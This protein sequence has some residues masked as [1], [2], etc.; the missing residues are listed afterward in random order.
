VNLVL[1]ATEAIGERGGTVTLRTGRR[2][3]GVA[4]LA[5]AVVGSEHPPGEYVFVDVPDNGPGV[6]PDV[7]ACMFD[8]FFT[9]KDAGHGLGLAVVVGVARAHH[10]AL[11][12]T[13]TPGEGTRFALYFAPY[14]T[15]DEERGAGDAGQV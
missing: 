14:Q 6:E 15:T 9:T 8:P 4:T 5:R 2:K 10:A 13:S 12:V 11:T 1:N 3:L 7:L